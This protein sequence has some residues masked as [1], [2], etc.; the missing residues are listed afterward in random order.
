MATLVLKSTI[1][2][3]SLFVGN[4]SCPFVLCE[5]YVQRDSLINSDN[6][7]N[8]ELDIFIV[9]RMILCFRIVKF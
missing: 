9:G 8:K 1:F 5:E 6:G 3:T 2:V 4:Q 7:E